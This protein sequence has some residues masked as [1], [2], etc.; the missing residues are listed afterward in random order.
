MS[1]TDN[2]TTSKTKTNE[3]Y[4]SDKDIESQMKDK[5]SSG[6]ESNWRNF[7]P[8]EIGQTEDDNLL[9]I[10]KN[11]SEWRT[12]LSKKTDKKRGSRPLLLKTR[13]GID[14]LLDIWYQNSK[15]SKES[16]VDSSKTKCK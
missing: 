5:R 7:L 9:S 12:G 14:S 16:N 8:G 4:K 13:P 10:F 2:R 15:E 1:I 3:H 11:T 6:V